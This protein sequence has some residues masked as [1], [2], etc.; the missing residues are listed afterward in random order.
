[1]LCSAMCATPLLNCILGMNTPR[2]ISCTNE[3]T[4]ANQLLFQNSTPLKQCQPAPLRHE[5]ESDHLHG[6][7]FWSSQ[8]A[9]HLS[10]TFLQAQGSVLMPLCISPP[11]LVNYWTRLQFE[12]SSGFAHP[13]LVS[14]KRLSKRDFLKEIV[15]SN[16]S[17][18]ST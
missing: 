7:R 15:K 13:K 12:S 6:P 16:V 10:C 11:N 18:S 17:K 14:K 8:T 2:S 5:N 3:P 9:N 1:M 4:S